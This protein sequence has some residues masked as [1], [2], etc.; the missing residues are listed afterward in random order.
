MTQAQ[1][2]ANATSSINSSSILTAAGGG[3]GA[4]TLSA[5]NVLLGNG[6]SPLQAVAPGANGQVLTSNGTT[7]VSQAPAGGGVTSLVAGSGISVS[8]A[9][10]AVTVSAVGSGSP[11]TSVGGV[12]SCAF[13]LNISGSTYGPGS[14]FG[15]A[16]LRW[17]SINMGG[18]PTGGSPGGTWAACGSSG[19]DNSVA[20]VF[21]R[22]A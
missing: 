20:A 14:T 19:S 3:T 21:V 9:T 4:A 2:V 5:N 12:G 6:T 18:L 13:L 11:T 10:G 8:A 16:S 15:G 7:W 17:C 1:N 22:T